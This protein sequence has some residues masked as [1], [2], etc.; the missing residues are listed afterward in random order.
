MVRDGN[1]ITARGAGAS[2]EFSLALIEMLGGDADEISDSIQ[3][4]NVLNEHIQ[5]SSPKE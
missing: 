1:I 3:Y 2:Y 4:T 5:K